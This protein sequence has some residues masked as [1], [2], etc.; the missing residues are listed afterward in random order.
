MEKKRSVSFNRG[1]IEQSVFYA[2]RKIKDKSQPSKKLKQVNKTRIMESLSLWR[3]PLEDIYESENLDTIDQIIADIQF[4]KPRPP[5]TLFMMEKT[6]EIDKSVN[7]QER[8]KKISEDW[9]KLKD[10]EKQKYKKASLIERDKFNKDVLFIKNFLYMG[11]DGVITK[12]ETPYDYFEMEK[13]MKLYDISNIETPDFKKK[14]LEEWKKL[15]DNEKSKYETMK[16]KKEQWLI[17]AKK[18]KNLNPVSLY[19]HEKI[20]ESKKENKD[21]PSVIELRKGW[22]NLSKKEKEKYEIMVESLLNEREILSNIYNINR[23]SQRGKPRGAFKM[24]IYDLIKEN[25][26]KVNNITVLDAEKMW[27]K[28]DIDLK[29]EYLKKAKRLQLANKYKEMVEKKKVQKRKREYH[30]FVKNI[31]NFLNLI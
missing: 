24:Y 21:V 19:V 12:E 3:K 2:K 28:L 15:P 6:K 31:L 14:T 29:E 13:R 22:S 20:N 27:K 18:L 7:I 11:E 17:K 4:K 26:G 9:K 30:I 8:N 23:K 1:S 25:K 10:G 5:F 16:E